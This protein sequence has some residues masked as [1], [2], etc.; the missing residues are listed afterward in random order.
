M[1]KKEIFFLC[2]SSMAVM[3]GFGIVGPILPQY[4]LTFNASYTLAGFV[5]SAF[6]L[7]RML[8]N[9]PSGLLADRIG[10]RRPLLLGIG[11]VTLSAL[12]CGFAQSIYELI[13]FRFIFGA[14]TAMFVI[15]ANVLIAEI[16]PP[17]ERG[18]YLSYYQGSFQMGSIVGPA[19][20][21][22]IAELAGLRT[23]F[24]L[25]AGL[26]ALSVC[27]TFLLIHEAPRT[28]SA[29]P[30]INVGRLL[31]L[32]GDRRLAAI[33]VTQLASFLTMS[34]IR[35]TML[36]LYGVDYLGLS[37]SEIGAV[38]SIGALVSFPTLMV[39]SNVV[40]RVQ[41]NRVISVGFLGLA[42]AV[43]LY[44]RA[45]GFDLVLVATV[46]LS[47]SQILINPSKT[48]IVGDITTPENRGLVMGAF[49]TAGDIGFFVGPAMAGYLTDNVH[50][51]SPFYLVTVL[52]VLSA[53]LA[54]HALH[55]SRLSRIDAIA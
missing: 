52:C 8:F 5:I 10:R 54:W 38:L 6:P 7:A 32:L 44:T 49:R 39:M 4:V 45:R 15:V 40:D 14:G 16:A 29:T 51:L 53:G 11:I 22:F 20:G 42:A 1:V 33:E 2:G 50:V 3:L 12:G 24:F 31:R 28:R 17:D 46:I 48:A 43:F 19:I 18:K 21:G 9:F 25:L 34:S 36:P 41:R 23:P 55:A 26:G 30:S 35:T 27:L 47:V 13:L 37:V